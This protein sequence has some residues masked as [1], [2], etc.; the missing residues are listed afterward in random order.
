MRQSLFIPFKYDVQVL[1]FYLH[2]YFADV[3]VTF[4]QGKGMPN[5]ASGTNTPKFDI[6][7]VVEDIEIYYF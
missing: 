5:G 7:F 6:K 1:N 2:S 4:N 3:R